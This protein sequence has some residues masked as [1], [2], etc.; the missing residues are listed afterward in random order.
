MKIIP[1]ASEDQLPDPPVKRKRGRP[2]KIIPLDKLKNKRKLSD[3]TKQK[4]AENNKKFS[5]CKLC[6]KQCRGFRGLVDHM[7]RDHSDYKPWECG[8]CETKT[9]F[10]KT[11]YRHLK[12]E[13]SVNEC[14]CPKCGK[15][16]SRAQ[17]MLF[18]MSKHDE[19]DDDEYFECGE[20]QAKFKKKE[21]LDQH[22]FKK[23]EGGYECEH[24]NK[25]FSEQSTLKEHTRIHT[26]ERPYQCTECGSTFSFQSTFLSHRKMHLREKGMSEEEAK[27]KLYYF[28]DVCGK[29]YANKAGLKIHKLHVHEKYSEEVPCDVCGISFRT[30]ELLKQHQEREHS[31]S[32]KFACEI[33]GQRFGNSYHLKRHA[34]SHSDEGFPCTQC[35][36]I[37][38]RKDGLDTH[39]SHA[40]KDKPNGMHTDDIAQPEETETLIENKLFDKYPEYVR[41]I[42]TSQLTINE[43]GSN[44]ITH[45]QETEELNEPSK[46]YTELITVHPSQQQ[47][48]KIVDSPSEAASI[49]DVE[50]NDSHFD[51]SESHVMET[52]NKDIFQVPLNIT[53]P[54][55]NTY[56]PPISYAQLD[57][58]PTSISLGT[59]GFGME[60]S[61]QV[62]EAHQYQPI[63]AHDIQTLQT[64]LYQPPPLTPT[65]APQ[66]Q[67]SHIS[68][69][70]SLMSQIN[71]LSQYKATSV[72]KSN[73]KMASNT[74]QNVNE[75]QPQ[76][77]MDMNLMNNTNITPTAQNTPPAPL[78]MCIPILEPH[79]STP[80]I[81]T[82]KQPQNQD[83][84]PPTLTNF[85][86][87]IN[88]EQPQE[89][90]PLAPRRQSVIRIN[91][92]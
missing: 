22:I 27:V 40:H 77:S 12:Q 39:F 91:R 41:T 20:C 42:D 57:A 82:N 10:V 45:E 15:T 61:L 35:S 78:P 33:C 6:S 4:I 48:H 69:Q 64:S 53:E 59:S 71:Q 80:M 36:R 92:K 23:H 87:N 46:C 65:T 9:A 3:M 90:A 83:F 66:F 74:K 79:M 17:S 14:P 84:K 28:C 86:R 47:L 58:K 34:S 75:F 31:E 1:T 67:T 30:R 5:I 8:F 37:F 51:I 73:I 29:S 44:N 7:H 49:T 70:L 38:K 13:H 32:P 72:T 54:V 2:R 16:Y 43:P 89:E 50:E 52:D 85:D 55:Q 25:R 24:C 56:Y 21:K 62:I 18:H 60:A 26:R 63:E 19:E 11:L 68:N 76:A 88:H 81:R